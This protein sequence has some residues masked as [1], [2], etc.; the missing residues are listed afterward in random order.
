MNKQDKIK[1]IAEGLG[2][3][4]FSTES[5]V[6]CMK[7]D[8]SKKPEDYDYVWQWLDEAYISGIQ[9]F[10]PYENPKHTW[11]VLEKILTDRTADLQICNGLMQDKRCIIRDARDCRADTSGHEDAKTAICEAYLSTLEGQE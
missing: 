9:Y 10:D 7:L 11:M 2:Y 8:S 5:G 1:R 4:A 6:T 3:R